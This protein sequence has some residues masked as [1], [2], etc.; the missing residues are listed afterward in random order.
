[1]RSVSRL[2]PRL[3]RR[4]QVLVLDHPARGVEAQADDV[5]AQ[6]AVAGYVVAALAQPGRGE[7]AQLHALA[8]A[9]RRRRGLRAELRA[10]A[11]GLDLD[12]D[13]RRAVE[14][15]QVDL[16]AD[17]DGAHVAGDDPPAV[18]RQPRRDQVLRVASEVLAG[19]R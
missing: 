10:G 15:D 16:P 17:V 14:R 7:A 4:A 8:R 19:E 13:E 9:D 2:S 12:E 11:A 5:E 3:E 18:A 6:V 1:M